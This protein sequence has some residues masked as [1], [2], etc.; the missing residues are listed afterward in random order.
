MKILI[1]VGHPAHVHFFKNLIGLLSKNGHDIKIVARNKEVVLDLLDNY[2][3]DY[4]V[5]SSKGNNFLSLG[6]EMIKRHY[7]FFKILRKT[8]PDIVLAGFDPSVAQIGKIL[9][10]P[11]IVFA[12]NRPNISNFPPIGSMVIPFAKVILSLSSVKYDFGP[13][14]VKVNSYKELAYLNP[15]YF[16]P[17]PK[18]TED[19]G[20]SK[21][22]IFVLLR[23]VSHS[24]YHDIGTV[25]LDVDAKIRL[26]QEL[27]KYATVLISSEVQLPIELEKYQIT[28]APEKIHDLIYYSKLLVCDSQTMTTEAGVL[29]TPAIRCNSFVGKG[30]MGNFIE[31][32][33]KYGLIYNYDNVDDVI[34]KAIGLLQNPNLKEEWNYKKE[35]LLNDKIDMTAFMLW[36]VENYPHS[37]KIMKENP[38]I[39]YQFK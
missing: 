8:N 26:V 34:S 15:N 19:F 36:F 16:K 4:E 17:N 23:F 1:S 22:E 27:E 2:G 30:D 21:N 39:Q 29:G 6:F 11:S 25:G 10:V 9:S 24:A 33:Q 37:F 35:Q 31:L 3:F 28:A 13:K 38:D 32:E 18:I 5:I 12:D 14:E 7:M 20:L